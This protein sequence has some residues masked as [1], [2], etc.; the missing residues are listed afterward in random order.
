MLGGL[1]LSLTGTDGNLPPLRGTAARC[2]P[3][4]VTDTAVAGSLH[5]HPVQLLPW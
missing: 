3:P 2:C 4:S 5:A 1:L